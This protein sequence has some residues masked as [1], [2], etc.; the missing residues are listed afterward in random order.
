MKKICLITT[1][2]LLFLVNTSKG[3]AQLGFSSTLTGTFSVI[4]AA[5]NP[6][7]STCTYSSS[8]TIGG[9]STFYPVFSSVTDLNGLG[10]Y[11]INWGGGS[12]ATT[13]GIWDLFHI[14]DG[15]GAVDVGIACGASTTS[16]SF[17][18]CSG[19]VHVDWQLDGSNNIK[20]TI[21]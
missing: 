12:P 19:T 16:T 11:G 18:G 14:S 20:I 9:M 2:L 21:Y 3:Q 7:S 8:F 1:F 6:G 5:H 13:G 15:C 17:T 4:L 10:V